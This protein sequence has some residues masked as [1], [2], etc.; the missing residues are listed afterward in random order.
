MESLLTKTLLISLNILNNQSAQ[1]LKNIE[2]RNCHRNYIVLGKT[3]EEL[4]S[5]LTTELNNYPNLNL[6]IIMADENFS[7]VYHNESAILKAIAMR[8]LF[9]ETR[10]K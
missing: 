1:L 4:R 8:I 6:E 3:N 9:Q 7:F 5:K 10:I 2:S